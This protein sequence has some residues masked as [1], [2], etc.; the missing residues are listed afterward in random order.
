MTRNASL[1]QKR[2]FQVLEGR[3]EGISVML[4]SGE[5][6]SDEHGAAVVRSL[7]KSRA[8]ARV[9]GM[10]G[11]ALR[12]A[13]METVID[14]ESA[15]AVMGL[16]E[17]VGSL[18]KIY[19]AYRELIRIARER[20]PDVVVLID[21]PD[22]NL[23]LA[24]ALKRSGFPILYFITPQ[25][26]AWRSG[27][28]KAIRRSVRKVAPIFPFE[29]SY[30]QRYGVDAEYV[31]HPF[32][33]RAPLAFDRGEFLRSL[34]LDPNRPVLA[35]LPG[36]RKA[37]AE[38][39]LPP[40]LGA[41]E[42]LRRVRPNFQ[43]IIPVASTLTKDFFAER[44]RGV[45]D[46]ALSSGQA[47]EVLSVARASI[48]ASGTATVEAALAE[49]P[50]LV[51]YRLSP[52]SHFIA[53]KL[54]RGVRH[55]AMPNLIAGKPVVPELLQ[56][57]VTPERLA[58]ELERFLGDPAYEKR[59]RKDLKIVGDRLRFGRKAECSAAQR[60]AE[61]IVEIAGEKYTRQSRVYR[62]KGEQ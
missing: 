8:D 7:L 50:F 58:M 35:L 10:G 31:G 1:I 5:A 15:A 46:L 40:L 2:P 14:S 12:A 13:G 54:V 22:F 23:R 48:V 56:D 47:R 36:S 57:E 51:V 34:G 27:R 18:R 32:L 24:R 29:E 6:S 28:I 43:A 52:V 53:R 21:F 19:A 38:M 25:L 44:T 30:F 26:W 42:Q 11:S 9:F 55:F 59:M 39:L 61:I 62:P 37:E 45:P 33:D 49:N 3:R 20:K 41:Y 17:V 16:T 4:V 60:T